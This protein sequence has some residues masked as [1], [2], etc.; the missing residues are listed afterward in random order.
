MVPAEQRRHKEIGNGEVCMAQIYN[1]K[2]LRQVK[3]QEFGASLGYILRSRPDWTNRYR[4]KK[5]K[6]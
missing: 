2:T 6:N 5:K 1:P 3:C 4:L